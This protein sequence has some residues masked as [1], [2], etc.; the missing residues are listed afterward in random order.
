MMAILWF[1]FVAFMLV[2]YV[3]LDGFD[4]GIGVVHLVLARDEPERRTLLST[5]GP[6]RDGNEEWLIGAGATLF[7]AFP[8]LYAASFSSFF[9]PL[10]IVLWLLMGRGIAMEF[11][12]HLDH[13]VW[14]P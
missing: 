14:P 11:R 1:G 13:T 4:L 6:L 12:N 10:M 7:P 8:T 9:I 2:T 3:V 5:I